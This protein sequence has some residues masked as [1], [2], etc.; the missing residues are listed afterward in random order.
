MI[1]FTPPDA[2]TPIDA[3]SLPSSDEVRAVFEH[4]SL[5]MA[6]SRNRVI[7]RCNRVFAQLF[8][9]SVADWVGQPGLSI[10][11]DEEAYVRFGELAGP[12]LATGGIYR[13][14]YQFKGVDGALLTCVVSASTVNPDRPTEGTIWVFDDV[15]AERAQQQALHEAL[16]RFESLM[17]N[18]PVGIIQTVNRCIV[19][20]NQRFLDMF[21]YTEDQAIGMPAVKLFPS[22]ADY[23]ELGRLAA[24]LLSQ[25]LPVD[26]EFRMFSSRGESLWVQFVG[27]LVDPADAS[28]GTFWIISDRTEARNQADSLRQALDENQ[29]IFDSAALGMVVL[30]Q[31]MVVR[32]N[33][34]LEAMFG[35]QAGGMVGTSTSLWYPSPEAFNWVAEHVYPALAGAQPATHE[36]Q[37][38]KADGSLVLG[39]H[40]G[41]R[42]G[43][44]WRGHVGCQFVVAGRHHRA[45]AQRRGFACCHIAEPGGVCQHRP[46]ADCHRHTGHHP[47]VQCSG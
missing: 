25:A 19:D 1:P 16:Q 23:A 14:E 11:R 28:K 13:G 34:Q 43:A 24:P 35:R 29:A 26:A 21:G 8:G 20:A 17:A 46:G 12:V 15:T 37:L 5:G 7:V 31:R 22:E 41:P 45:A 9:K 42:L 38:R 6:L 33:P 3:A 18:A 10:F 32:C 40:D 44:R 36:L 2:S 4:A 47:A 27:Y 30:K 39:A